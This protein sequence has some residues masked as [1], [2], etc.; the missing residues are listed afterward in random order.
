MSKLLSRLLALILAISITAV[1]LAISHPHRSRAQQQA[2]ATG[3]NRNAAVVAAT[4]EVLKETSAIRELPVLRSV[5][6]G[7]Q[8]R[9]QIERMLI[10]KLNQHV[11]TQEMH[12]LE[13]SLKKFGLAPSTFTYRSFIVD[14]LTEQVAGYYDP[15]AQ[16]FHLADWIEL[17]AQKPVMAHELTHALQDQHFN[18]RR[19]ENWPRGDSDAELA[20]HALVEGDATLAMM[21]YL[22]K[23][24]AAALAFGRSFGADTVASKQFDSAPRA[25][26]ET[27]IFPYIQGMDWATKVHHR[28]G[29]ELLSRSYTRLPESTEQILHAEK[30]FSA[31]RPVKVRL[32]DLTT[33]LNRGGKGIA[34]SK[35]ETVNSK[36]QTANSRGKARKANSHSSTRNPRSNGWRQIETDVNGEWGYYLVLD[37]FLKTAAES[38]RA[39]AGW[40]GDRYALYEHTKS[41]ALFLAQVSAW[42]TAADA[43][44]FFDAY[45]KRTAL[46]YP[47]GRLLS[48]NGGQAPETLWQTR[49]GGVL[50]R[51]RGANVVILE[52]VPSNV[53]AAA[54]A[55]LLSR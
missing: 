38:K 47:D 26:R 18:L 44:E 31:E 4:S 37:E 30:Y 28:G 1:G 23:N 49:E 6:S 2:V 16:R 20:A 5:R 53:S 36:Q 42:D 24:P 39:A 40:A 46:R 21:Y 27:L 7:A 35:Q 48:Q 55:D 54:V 25:L 8:S 14:L 12:A 11:T 15:A 51:L 50:I 9:V 32:A 13:Q 3:V 41:G 34:D 17:D 29:W 43:Q 10:S 45:V 22:A 19:F 52:G 33:L